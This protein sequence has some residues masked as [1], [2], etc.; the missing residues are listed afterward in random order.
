MEEVEKEVEKEVRKS[1]LEARQAKAYSR[2]IRL[3]EQQL[4]KINL[5][6]HGLI[7]LRRN[8]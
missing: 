4:K 7:S 2:M 1:E 5:P 8:L 3:V 6:S